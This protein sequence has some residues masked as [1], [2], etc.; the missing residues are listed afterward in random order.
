MILLTQLAL[1]I[2]DSRL[3]VL[4][5][6]ELVVVCKRFKGS[7]ITKDKSSVYSQFI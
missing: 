1:V 5:T 6:A 7:F 3:P 4:V 2:V